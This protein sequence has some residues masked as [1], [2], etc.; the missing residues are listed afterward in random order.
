MDVSHRGFTDL[1]LVGS[2]H[3]ILDVEPDCHI[4][5]QLNLA[6]TTGSSPGWL[7]RH[8]GRVQLHDNKKLVDCVQHH[9][10]NG[11]SGIMV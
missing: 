1:G 11:P 9:S 5:V 6:S 10:P 8:L 7:L 3:R 4:E 2:Y